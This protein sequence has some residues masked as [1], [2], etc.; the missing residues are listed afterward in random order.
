MRYFY[1]QLNKC[2]PEQYNPALN[3]AIERFQSLELVNFE[4]MYKH[5]NRG[6]PP[7]S[8]TKKIMW[9]ITEELGLFLITK[10]E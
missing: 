10:R 3:D 1:S 5:S 2:Y 8:A 6:R 4:F 7:L 9:I